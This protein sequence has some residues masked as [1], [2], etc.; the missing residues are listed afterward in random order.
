MK[1]RNKI[2]T[3]VEFKYV[4]TPENMTSFAFEY[5]FGDDFETPD[6]C[7][8][9]KAMS[10]EMLY[11]TIIDSI[12]EIDWECKSSDDQYTGRLSDQ[13]LIHLGELFRRNL[14]PDTHPYVETLFTQKYYNCVIGAKDAIKKLCQGRLRCIGIVRDTVMPL[15]KAPVLSKQINELI[16][17]I[18]DK[19]GNKPSE[20]KNFLTPDH[21]RMVRMGCD[22]SEWSVD[23]QEILL[24]C[25][26]KVPVKEDGNYED[27]K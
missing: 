10:E 18:L 5:N 4:N 3:E 15:L 21:Y 25:L 7:V 2:E 12:D 16:D 26:K 6:Y 9:L 19:N 20:F 22:V 1:R 11:E 14:T 27:A 24:E 13:L 23:E 17:A 8:T